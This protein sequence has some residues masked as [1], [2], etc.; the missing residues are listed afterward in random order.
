MRLVIVI[1]IPPP[2]VLAWVVL[3][4]VDWLLDLHQRSLLTRAPEEMLR[5][6]VLRRLWVADRLRQYAPR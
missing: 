6:A 2:R 3:E 4:A 1:N 5:R